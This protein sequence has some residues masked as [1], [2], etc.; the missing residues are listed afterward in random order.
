MCTVFL[1]ALLYFLNRP[2]LKPLPTYDHPLAD[3][4]GSLILFPRKEFVLSDDWSDS[5][6]VGAGLWL[7]A[8]FLQT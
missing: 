3:P 8:G 4:F 5:L 2:L 6:K 7:G 1:F